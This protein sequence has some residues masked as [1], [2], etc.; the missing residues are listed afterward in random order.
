M[1][2]L[3][4]LVRRRAASV[5]ACGLKGTRV[6][7]VRDEPGSSEKNEK[8]GGSCDEVSL[9]LSVGPHVVAVADSEPNAV[10][11]ADRKSVV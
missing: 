1:K 8:G 4:E 9:T 5:Q 11:D 3:L 7:V 6:V 10:A 2:I